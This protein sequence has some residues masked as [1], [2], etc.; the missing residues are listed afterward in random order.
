METLYYYDTPVG[1]IGIVQDGNAVTGLYFTVPASLLA[2]LPVEESELHRRAAAQLHAYFSGKRK[3]FELPLSPRGTPFQRR[4]WEALQTI[5]YGETRS[6]GQI[7]AQVGNAK[8]S[9]AVGMANNRNPISILIP[10]HRVIGADGKLTGYGGGM[11][12][13]EWLLALERTV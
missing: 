9:R 8:A 7:A 6:Y 13:K 5:P 11:H 3:V 12:N 10:C 4:V 2:L 1:K